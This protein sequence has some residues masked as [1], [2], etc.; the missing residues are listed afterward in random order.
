[1]HIFECGCQ[2]CLEIYVICVII[3]DVN[4]RQVQ[5]VAY[6]KFDKGHRCD[7][8][9]TFYSPGPNETDTM[10]LQATSWYCLVPA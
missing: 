4:L 2:V 9:V 7:W 6:V 3:V 10:W 1:M 5:K 8:C